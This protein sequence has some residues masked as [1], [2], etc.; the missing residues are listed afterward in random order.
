LSKILHIVGDS[1]YGGASLIIEKLA[2]AAKEQGHQVS[3]L[4]TDSM[5]RERLADAGIE[6]V[7]LNCVWRPIRP[8]RDII[9]LIRLK[10]FLASKAFDIVHTHTSKGGFVGRVAARWAG[11][12]II[13]HTVHGFAFHEASSPYALKFYSMLERLAAHCC[14]SIV[15]VSKFHCDWAQKLGISD[16]AKCLAIPNGIDATRVKAR[17]SR[18]SV[19]DKL[20]I[21]KDEIMCFTAGRLAKQK[22]L[23]ILLHALAG[24]KRPH[25]IRAIIAGEGPDRE[26][27]E[28]LRDDLHLQ[29]T[30]NFVGFRKDLGD[31]LH[32]SDIVVLPS[33]REGLSISLL[34]AMAAG[35][36]VITTDI[37]SNLEVS[38]NGQL[39]RIIRVGRTSELARAILELAADENERRR[40]GERGLAEFQKYYTDEAMV[41]AYMA[42]YDRLVKQETKHVKRIAFL[43]NRC[44]F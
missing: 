31:L 40:L 6:V 11:V 14:D 18:A 16:P 29:D 34:E 44:W 41:N 25:L 19:R 39:A 36:P 5:F 7:P 24:I 21:Q 20:A 17:K 12:P 13:I 22:G 3:V 4:A 38:R 8:T 43:V 1:K 2:N 35:K 9:G 33:L 26:K 42:L 15:T 32:A 27:L 23:D 30:V 10:R 37:G 28:Q